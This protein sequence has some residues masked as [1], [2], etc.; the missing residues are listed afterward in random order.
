MDSCTHAF[1]LTTRGPRRGVGHVS[2]STWLPSEL[3]HVSDRLFPA[4]RA[5]TADSRCCGSAGNLYPYV[6]SLLNNGA[7]PTAVAATPVKKQ[8]L[9]ESVLRL[10]LGVVY[11]KSPA[12]APTRGYLWVQHSGLCMRSDSAPELRGGGMTC[13]GQALL[14]ESP[15]KIS[16]LY[17]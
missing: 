14:T 8:W 3:T 16:A 6:F 11:W 2:G 9:E 5:Q 13:T 12:V 7:A 4:S 10:S 1:V 15:T 17:G